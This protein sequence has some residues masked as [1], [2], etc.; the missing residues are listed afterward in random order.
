[1]TFRFVIYSIFP[2]S[3][4]F[5]GA[6]H[7]GGQLQALRRFLAN[8]LDAKCGGVPKAEPGGHDD[9][10]QELRASY[11]AELSEFRCHAI[12]QS[13]N[14]ITSGSLLRNG[15]FPLQSKCST[16]SIPSSKQV[17]LSRTRPFPVIGFFSCSCSLLGTL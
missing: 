4:R 5:L 16:G 1:M 15:S 12:G 6:D 3:I 11:A 9:P 8:P 2:R 13:E 17:F 14:C 10:S 7:F